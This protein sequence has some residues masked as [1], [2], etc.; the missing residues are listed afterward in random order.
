MKILAA[1]PEGVWP[2]GGGELIAIRDERSKVAYYSIRN[3]SSGAQKSLDLK[4]VSKLLRLLKR[5]DKIKIRIQ[6]K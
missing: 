2:F 6:K 1:S 5:Q 4:L 3:R